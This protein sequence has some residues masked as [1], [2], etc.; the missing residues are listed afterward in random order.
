M[1]RRYAGHAASRR[2]GRRCRL[3][4]GPRKARTSGVARGAGHCTVTVRSHATITPEQMLFDSVAVPKIDDFRLARLVGVRHPLV[5]VANRF[6]R[7]L[8]H[9]DAARDHFGRSA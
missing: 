2:V 4:T 7:P 3:K 5:C 8:R 1:Q 6:V 9:G